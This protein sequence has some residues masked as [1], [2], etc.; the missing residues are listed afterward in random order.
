MPLQ[1]IEHLMTFLGNTVSTLNGEKYNKL[2]GS[3][4]LS[5]R[6]IELMNFLDT[7]NSLMGILD[8]EKKPPLNHYQ[9]LS[10]LSTEDFNSKEIVEFH[11]SVEGIEKEVINFCSNISFFILQEDIFS[12]FSLY[13]I[14]RKILTQNIFR[15]LTDYST[16]KI[17][18]EV[19]NL[20]RRGMVH[21][22]G[23]TKSGKILYE[24]ES[25]KKAFLQVLLDSIDDIL[26]IENQFKTFKEEFRDAVKESLNKEEIKKLKAFMTF[27][28]SY[29]TILKRL[30]NM[31]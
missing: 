15:N 17:S 23:R 19:N 3:S 22:I 25:V 7:F 21:K 28:S 2:T 24:M 6:L 16:G 1:E 12:I 11:P 26:K 31:L 18:K 30:K 27:L 29:F 10:R 9:K 14:T 8:K 13:F 20:V 5:S 4:F